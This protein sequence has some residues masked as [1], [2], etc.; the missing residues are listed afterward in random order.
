MG[1]ASWRAGEQGRGQA[2]VKMSQYRD[3]VSFDRVNLI[4]LAGNCFYYARPATFGGAGAGGGSGGDTDV[5]T[6]V[7]F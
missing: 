3:K 5:R 4:E 7:A 6:A 1:C 2:R